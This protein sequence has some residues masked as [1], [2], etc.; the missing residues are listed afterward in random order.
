MLK[1]QV[2]L[3]LVIPVLQ[4]TT[5][6]AGSLILYD[7]SRWVRIDLSSYWTKVDDHLEPI[8]NTDDVEIG[9]ANIVLNATGDASFQGDV[10][11]GNT[12]PN[13]LLDIKG[14]S[15]TSPGQNNYLQFTGAN[16]LFAFRS[17]NNGNT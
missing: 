11:I 2:P 5:V 3:I 12:T 17:A 16:P 14:V 13:A 4:V 15:G 1:Q 10:A 9:G 8:D 7:G 6:N